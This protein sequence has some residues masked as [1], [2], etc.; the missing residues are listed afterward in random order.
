VY[1]ARDPR[2]NREVAIKCCGGPCRRRGPPP[3]LHPGSARR[4]GP[5]SPALITIYE[6]ESANGH[7]FIVMEY[8]RGKSLDARRTCHRSRPAAEGRR[9]QRHLQLRGNT[10]RD[11]DQRACLC[12]YVHRGHVGRS[13]TRTTETRSPRSNLQLIMRLGEVSPSGRYGR[14]AAHGLCLLESWV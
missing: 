13:S 8:V 14:S 2:L 4:L 9:P 10:V 3:S 11:G 5:Q 1:R 12:G 7:D 6:I